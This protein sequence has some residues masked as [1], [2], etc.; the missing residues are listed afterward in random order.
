[1]TWGHELPKFLEWK[2]G[3]DPGEQKKI[4]LKIT[5]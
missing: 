1:M 3:S 4:K 2:K 5:Y